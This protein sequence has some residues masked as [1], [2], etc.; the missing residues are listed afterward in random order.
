MWRLRAGAGEGLRGASEESGARPPGWRSCRTAAFTVRPAPPRAGGALASGASL[1]DLPWHTCC[2]ILIRE[3]RGA[4]STCVL[5]FWVG[6]VGRQ[7]WI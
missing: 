4:A 7:L 5:Q 1:C 2:Y 6:T 3:R